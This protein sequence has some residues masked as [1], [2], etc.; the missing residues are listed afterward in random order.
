MA[1]ALIVYRPAWRLTWLGRLAGLIVVAGILA[2]GLR[3]AY[4]FLAVSQP[5]STQCL[6]IEGWVADQ[7]LDLLI[8]E[9]N[10]G[11]YAP[12]YLT[13][14]PIRNNDPGARFGSYPELM[15]AALISRGFSADRLIAAPSPA[16][17]K[18]RTYASAQA[19][20]ERLQQMNVEC[21]SFNLV[22]EG[23]HAR[24]SRLLFALAFGSRTRIG[25]ISLKPDEYDPRHWWHT[26][27]GVR[28]ILS[29]AIAYVY[30]RCI[31]HP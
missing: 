10:R 4:P 23:A 2:V 9:I 24:R 1:F 18:D 6:V 8:A 19:L 17:V 21:G 29:E 3:C 11:H 31:F 30:A 14:G 13:G 25:V 20:K 5:V 15:R 27:A 12:I 16:V 22:T 28:D 7:E 26:S